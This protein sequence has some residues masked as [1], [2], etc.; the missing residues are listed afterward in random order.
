MDNRQYTRLIINVEGTYYTESEINGSIE[1]YGIIRDISEQ[2]IQIRI[3]LGLYPDAD[4][5]FVKGSTFTFQY[6]DVY[7]VCNQ[8]RMDILS[9]EAM[10][11]WTEI[12]GNMLIAGCYISSPSEEFMKYLKVRTAS[13]YAR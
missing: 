5:V 12:S 7:E 8:E 11:R 9:G 10:I 2:G 6:A 1:V 3:D 4:K 13:R